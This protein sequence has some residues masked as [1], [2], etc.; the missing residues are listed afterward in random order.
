MEHVVGEVDDP[1]AEETSPANTQH[2]TDVGPGEGV[3][4]TVDIDD[5]HSF[6]QIQ[7]GYHRQTEQ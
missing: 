1:R 5:T 3:G 6:F 2:D 4:I 7:L